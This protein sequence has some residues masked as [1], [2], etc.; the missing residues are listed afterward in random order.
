MAP[1]DEKAPGYTMGNFTPS[2]VPGCRAP[3]FWLS[4]KRSL[5]DAFGPGYTLLR[6]D[7]KVDVTQLVAAAQAN[8]VPLQVL[9]L[10]GQPDIPAAYQHALVICRPDQHVVWRGH[11]VPSQAEELVQLLRGARNVAQ[12]K[13]Q[14]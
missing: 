10:Q 11:A 9:D 14:I 5:Y 6:F 13:L 7:A 3:H 1:D 2:T 8:R 12:V 4:D